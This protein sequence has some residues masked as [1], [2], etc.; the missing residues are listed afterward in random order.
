MAQAWRPFWIH[1]GAEYLIGLGLVAAGFQNPEPAFPVIAGALILINAALVDGP[2]GAWRAATRPQH[3]WADVAVM[4]VIVII[5][6]LPFLDIDATSRLMMIGAV[7]LMGVFWW[8]TNFA[9]PAQRRRSAVDNP[10]RS[11]ELGRA[12]GRLVNFGRSA[13]RKRRGG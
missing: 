3:R 4:A 6:V 10:N 7:A 11:V 5:A 1:Q 9:T 12:A 13:T 2:L 8:T